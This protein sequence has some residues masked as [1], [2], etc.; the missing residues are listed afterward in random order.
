MNAAV[1]GDRDGSERAAMQPHRLL[2]VSVWI[3]AAVLAVVPILVPLILRPRQ[4]G[5]D[6][7]EVVGTIVYLL[8]GPTY[9]V[10][11]AVIVSRQPRNSVGWML[12]A[13]ATGMFVSVLAD[14]FAPGQPSESTTAGSLV[15]LAVASVSW[16][17]F[18]FPVFHI[19]LT[20]PDGHVLS[21]RWRVLVWLEGSMV[22]FMMFTALFS[23]EIVNVDESWSVANP[24]G[25]IP[26]SL[27]DVVFE[28]AW[29]K[30]LLVLVI[31]GLTSIVLRF[32]RSHGVERQQ[33]KSL[34][35]AVSFFAVV[36]GGAAV[37]SGG[38]DSGLLDLLLPV[39]MVGI[40][41]AVAL[42]V[43]RYRLFD[44]DRV[45]SR[46][47]TYTVVV[48]LLALGVAGVSTVVGTQFRQPWVVAATTLGV[49]AAFNPLR[50]RV[51]TWVDRRFNRSRY[52][53]ELVMAGFGVSLRDEVDADAIA[54]GWRDVVSETMQPAMV[55]VWVKE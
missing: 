28:Q 32:R 7:A 34:L 47:V 44:I 1:V 4:I 21:P 19:L 10:T 33:M 40:G 29:D 43:L 35:Y 5:S 45:M 25:F 16:V 52:D 24:I 8:V 2:P 53:A 27:F 37:I 13:V 11:G 23:E 50:R 17:F 6:F 22:A 30:L 26:E 9:A 38:E 42:A 41:L 51:Q 36:Y 3:Y 46:T 39:A 18:I 55:G 15:L 12:M 20:F 48:G 54:N 31:G 49:A 14:I